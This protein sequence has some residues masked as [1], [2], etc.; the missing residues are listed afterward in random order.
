[1]GIFFQK[2]P[3]KSLNL[4]RY[5]S[6]NPSN[7]IDPEGSITLN[8]GGCIIGGA[9]AAL[10]SW[11][12]HK[13]KEACGTIWAT[14]LICE[15]DHVHTQV[16]DTGKTNWGCVKDCMLD[17]AT[18]GWRGKVFMTICGASVANCLGAFNIPGQLR[19]RLRHHDPHGS[20]KHNYSHWQVNWWCNKK[21]GSG[22]AVRWPSECP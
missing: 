2:D 18:G 11:H 22:G 10:L 13:C 3:Y 1:M 19:V 7:Y 16:Y 15:N 8:V 20:G 6:S 5:C 21:K 14:R 12:Y 4:Y 9:C 17:G